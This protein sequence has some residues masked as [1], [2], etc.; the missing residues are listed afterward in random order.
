VKVRFLVNPSA[1]KGQT[2]KR[3]KK[4]FTD[5]GLDVR[6][7]EEM[8]MLATCTREAVD[9]KVGRIV[10]VGGDGSLNTV[11]NSVDR[12]DIQLGIIPTGSGND[13][14]RTAG[15]P[16]KEPEHYLNPCNPRR[17]DLGKADDRFFINIFGSGFDADVAKGMQETRLPGDLGYFVSVL[18]TLRVFQSP[19]VTVETDRESLELE[20]M[21]VSVGN[22][23]FHGGMFMLTPWAQ[24]DDGELD[25]CLVRKIPKMRFLSLIPTSITGKHVNIKDIVSIHRF[26]KMKL[27]YSHP[28]YYH[29]DGEPS[30]K[31]VEHVEISLKPEALTFVYP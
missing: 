1:G 26:K 20:T 5:K 15:I 6:V 7:C 8:G 16:F 13:F 2:G 3:W 31:K 22:G 21:T 9:D 19:L 17:I 27:Y 23:Q 12:F 28:V 18:R 14:V 25:L 29:L 24:L 11:I 10:V 30:A 4:I